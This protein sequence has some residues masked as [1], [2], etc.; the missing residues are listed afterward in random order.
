[1]GQIKVFD[2]NGQLLLTAENIAEII[3]CK[4]STIDAYVSRGQMPQPVGLNG[5]TRLWSEAKIQ[6]WLTHRDELKIFIELRDENRWVRWKMM[7]T[8]GSERMR[9]VP[10]T[11]AGRNASST[12][13]NTWASHDDVIASTIGD[14]IGFVLNGDGVMCIDLDHCVEADKPNQLA[15]D[16]IATLPRTYIEFS[17]SGDGLHIWGF[18]SVDKGSR[19]T[20]DG[21]SVEI[22]ATGRYMTVTGKP[23]INAS[24][25]RLI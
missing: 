24:F 25:A 7:K 2:E 16:F 13:S 15:L 17:P 20:I 18:G 5:R 11:I 12:D 1:M 6:S 9:K 23:F 3:G 4:T 10:M 21:L 8:A 22:Y 14:G 19:R